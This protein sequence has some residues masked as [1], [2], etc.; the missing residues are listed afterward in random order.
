MAFSG[1]LFFPGKEVAVGLNAEPRKNGVEGRLTGESRVA[2]FPIVSKGTHPTFKMHMC[3]LK[4][5]PQRCF[6]GTLSVL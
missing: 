2:P 5:A 3:V 1:D 6:S 4:P